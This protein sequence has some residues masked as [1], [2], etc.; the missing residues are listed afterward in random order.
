MYRSAQPPSCD[1]CLGQFSC[2]ARS[3]TRERYDPIQ[4]RETVSG[5][6]PMRNVAPWPRS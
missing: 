5:F 1:A 4:S 6:E 2:S 3:L